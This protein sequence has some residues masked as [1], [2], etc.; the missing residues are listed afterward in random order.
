MLRRERVF[1]LRWKIW[2]IGRD[3]GARRRA[4]ST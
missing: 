4:S 2:L 3:D 1:V